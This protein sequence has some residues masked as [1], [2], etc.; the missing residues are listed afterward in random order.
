MFCIFKLIAMGNHTKSSNDIDYE[1]VDDEEMNLIESVLSKCNKQGADSSDLQ[2]CEID[3]VSQGELEAIEVSL[4]QTSGP[5]HCNIQAVKPVPRLETLVPGSPE[6]GIV[7]AL[8]NKTCHGTW[9]IVQ[10][11][12]AINPPRQRKH[13]SHRAFLQDNFVYPDVRRLFHGTDRGTLEKIMV[14]GFNRNFNGRNGTVY[15]IGVYFARDSSYSVAYSPPDEYGNQCMCVADVIVGEI[16]QGHPQMRAPPPRATMAGLCD[17]AV[18]SVSDPSI[19]V[20][21]HDDQV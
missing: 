9:L 21:F 3:I 10:V 4:R 11:E 20:C 17:T 8:F 19:F 12:S 1:L 5:A 2:S 16:A 14:N 6:F 15:G 7:A 13:D 18:N